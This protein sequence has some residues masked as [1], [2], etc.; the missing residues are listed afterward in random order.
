MDFVTCRQTKGAESRPV[1][2]SSQKKTQPTNKG[3]RMGRYRT[4]FLSSRSPTR[5]FFPPA[6]MMSSGE[7]SLLL[8]YSPSAI[9]CEIH[10]RR[11]SI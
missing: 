1:R 2:L 8:A 9:F 6:S 3:K 11:V 7:G 5:F 4:M 10:R